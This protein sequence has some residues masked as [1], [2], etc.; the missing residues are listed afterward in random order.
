MNFYD[1]YNLLSNR[2]A[3][4]TGVCI[5]IR[6]EN[7]SRGQGERARLHRR[8]NK[9]LGALVNLGQEYFFLFFFFSAGLKIFKIRIWG[10]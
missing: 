1:D 9:Q 8:E 7:R 10:S 4:K 2:A 3:E 5:H 6:R